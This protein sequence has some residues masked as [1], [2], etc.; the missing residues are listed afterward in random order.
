M[1]YFWKTTGVPNVVV[2]KKDE[3]GHYKTVNEAIKNMPYK[4]TYM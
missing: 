4:A 3:S 2:A 1:P